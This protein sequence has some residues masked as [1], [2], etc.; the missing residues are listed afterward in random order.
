MNLF[1]VNNNDVPVLESFT[2]VGNKVTI[3]SVLREDIRYESSKA[4]V[5]FIQL[6]NI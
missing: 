4:N 6:Y 3:V 1:N 5:T 2:C